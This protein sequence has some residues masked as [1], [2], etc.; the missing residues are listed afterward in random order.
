MRKILIFMIL[1]APLQVLFAQESESDSSGIVSNRL[2]PTSAPTLLFN[3]AD[4]RQKEDRKKKKKKKK[5]VYYNVKTKKSYLKQT[6]RNQ[7]IYEFF[8]YSLETR[9]VDPYIRDIYWVDKKDNVI[10][11]K[12]FDSSRG[13][14]LHGPYEKKNGDIV[15][16]SGMF[17]FGTKHG[18]WMKYD[19]KNIL[20]DKAHFAEGWPKESRVTYYNRTDRKIEKVT[21]MEYDLKE[22]NFFHFYEDGQVAVTGEYQYGEKVGVWTE[23]WHT[24]KDKTIKK[25]EIQYQE[26]PYTK[27]FTPFIKAEWDKEGNIIYKKDT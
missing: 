4:E 22:G 14:L 26:A 7:T 18:R 9:H 19:S 3:E 10:R 21:P 13:Y 6:F 1:T 23:Y 2:L 24:N 8:H 17:Y 12:N 27:N 15:V 11:T 16:E 20:V 25:R 5:N